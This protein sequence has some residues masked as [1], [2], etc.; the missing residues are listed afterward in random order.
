[1]QKYGEDYID[2]YLA[3]QPNWVQGHLG[4]ARSIADGSNYVTLDSTHAI[5]L[6][7]KKAGQPIELVFSEAD[8]TPVFYVTAGIF[9]DAPHPNFAKL[10]LTWLMQPEQQERAGP[11]SPRPDVVPLASSG[12][13]PLGEM[14]LANNYRD[15]V[16]D[17]ALLTRLRKKFEAAIGPIQNTGG[18]R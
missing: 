1:M 17:E 6:A 3:N 9:K 4:V 7:L 15:F 13:K 18:V 12:L 10:Y 8:P 2:K 11:Y 14:K 16:T 5:T